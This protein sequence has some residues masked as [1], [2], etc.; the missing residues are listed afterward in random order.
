MDQPRQHSALVFAAT[1]MGNAGD[2]STR[3]LEA[4]EGADLIAAED[5]RKF[6]QLASR[7]NVTING[8]VISFFE[9]NELERIEQVLQ[10]VQSGEQ[11]LVV[12]DAGM[13]S[14]SDPGYRL[15]NA[16]I[17]AH[18]DFTVLPGP[19]AVL[20]A[21]VHSGMPS[22]RFTFEGFLPRKSGERKSALR[23][24]DTETRTMVFFEAPHRIAKSL[25][26]MEEIFGSDR[27]AVVCR[28]LTK[29]YEEVVRG[30]I[31]EL[32]QWA[33]GDIRGEITVVVAGI[34]Q[35]ELKDRAG[36][37]DMQSVLVRVSELVNEGN[38]L[39]DAAA[40]MATAAGL[41][42]R[43]VYQAAIELKASRKGASKRD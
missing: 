40:H 35:E 31:G 21:L 1:P 28:E 7:L 10:A 16:A 38:S 8:R 13:P 23:A 6:R 19:S 39:K 2:A 37:G 33:Q 22:D 18:I 34:D 42:K 11:V 5:T 30:P 29:T 26:D 9:G 17:A 3:L 43:E 32:V 24:L 41:P 14:V 27:Q 4:I 36:F 20:T 25:A 12:S 15:V